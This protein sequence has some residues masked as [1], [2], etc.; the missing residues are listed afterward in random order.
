MTT[1][2]LKV[3]LLFF[4]H[5]DS[6]LR[7]NVHYSLVS[8]FNVIPRRRPESGWLS[9][10]RFYTYRDSHFRGND[11]NICL[12]DLRRM[13]VIHHSFSRVTLNPIHWDRSLH[14]FDMPRK[15]IWLC[16]MGSP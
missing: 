12:V 10:H 9:K 14:L 13:A 16:Y 5:L 6:R 2:W 1:G 7:G 8:L 15:C 3:R 4:R 11:L